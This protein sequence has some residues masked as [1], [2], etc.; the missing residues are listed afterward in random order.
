MYATRPSPIGGTP[1]AEAYYDRDAR[2][3]FPPPT[4]ADYPMPDRLPPR[5]DERMYYP[6]PEDPY[7]PRSAG[8][9][10]RTPPPPPPAMAQNPYAPTYPDY[11]PPDVPHY[12]VRWETPPDARSYPAAPP[13]DPWRAAHR[14]PSNPRL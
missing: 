3:P 7:Y 8:F 14:E 12:D 1:R 10:R 6:P 5:R 9:A 11:R 4:E 13:P 2:V